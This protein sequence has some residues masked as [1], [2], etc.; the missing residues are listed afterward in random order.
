[1]ARNKDLLGLPQEDAIWYF[2]YRQL[3]AEFE[4]ERGKLVRP[5]LMVL[6]NLTDMTMLRMDISERKPQSA[7]VQTLLKE[8]M[9]DPNPS[10]GHKPHRPERVLFEAPQLAQ[11]LVI[12]LSELEIKSAYEKIEGLMEN[13]TAEL[14]QT[15][16]GSDVP[17]PGGLL[18]VEGVTPEMIGDL[19]AAAADFY[20]AAPFEELSDSQPL[21]VDLL[22]EG[23][24]VYI[25]MMG[26]GGMEYGIVLYDSWE[27]LLASY[28][29]SEDP[30]QRLPQGGWKAL[31]FDP[32]D[33]LPDEDLEAIEEYGW[34]VADA[35]AYPLPVNLMPDGP[36]RPD[37]ETLLLYETLLRAVP[38]FV[39]E[40]L[41]FE[42]NEGDYRP[43]TRQY[44]IERH[45]GPVEVRLTY[46]AGEFPEGFSF[47]PH[48]DWMAEEDE[49][50]LLDLTGFDD[51]EEDEDFFFDPRA[52]EG[53]MAR[54]IGS[55]TGQLEDPGLE[56]A[57][58]LIYEAF[59][60]PDPDIRIEMAREALDI[61]PNCADAYV[62]LA[63]E[64]A[65]TLEEAAE[66]YQQGVEAGERALGDEYFENYAGQ[67]WGLIE[68]RPY[69]R[70]R[71]GL[72]GCLW[73]LRKRKEARG[74]FEALLNLNPNDNQGI[75]Y[76]LLG[77]LLEMKLYDEARELLERYAD[78]Y[79]AHWL[80]DR[81][82]L[83]FQAHGASPQANQNLQAA[84]QYNSHVP[85]YL[86]GT[87]RMPL[88]MPE[89]ISPGEESEAIAYA[90]DHL[91]IWRRLPGAMDWLKNGIQA[92][93]DELK[94][95]KA[96]ITKRGRRGKG[97]K[98]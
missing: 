98:S 20:R 26:Y 55:L 78:D 88:L 68:T 31:T 34:R 74:H 63:E 13:L 87:V 97:K 17:P 69:M 44:T 95:E 37:R 73:G 57:Q 35:N 58:D 6:M 28:K 4:N 11:A 27:D 47:H 60:E 16:S 51:E 86:T 5:Y 32:A 70:A 93:I 75:R 29:V 89:M 56:E 54:A 91:V 48:L 1:M 62:L 66:Y 42:E 53:D 9:L 15:L 76:Q 10:T 33:I 41:V 83:E 67:F 8:A 24:R 3:E 46:P 18:E 84:L 22:P 12:E 90:S 25:Q 94:A 59:D 30:L 36:Q 14:E 79:S 71:A 49:G 43:A 65:E 7:Q 80:W 92:Q 96:R 82:L 72:A 61:S 52:S 21:A 38:R 85:G 50:D 19:F 77:L 64:E 40:G 2:A 45:G 81:A 23:R 39:K